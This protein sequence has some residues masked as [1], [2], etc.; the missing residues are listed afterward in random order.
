MTVKEVGF[1][2]IKEN[3]ASQI[4]AMEIEAI[5]NSIVV[6]FGDNVDVLVT[7]FQNLSPIYFVSN[8]RRCWSIKFQNFLIK[9]ESTLTQGLNVFHNFG[10]FN[11]DQIRSILSDLNF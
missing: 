4:K 6:S 9:P 8:I 1:E 11:L 2:Q 7:T 3:L 5:D 10:S